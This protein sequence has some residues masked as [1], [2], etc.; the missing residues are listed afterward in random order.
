MTAY[1][2]V[3]RDLSKVTPQ[4]RNA[5]SGRTRFDNLEDFIKEHE[6]LLESFEAVTEIAKQNMNLVQLLL[7]QKDGTKPHIED[8]FAA[9][10]R[11]QANTIQ[12]TNQF[13]PGS[14]EKKMREYRG[15]LRG[16]LD[17]FGLAVMIDWTER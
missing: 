11:F 5:T 14:W 7:G 3:K 4:A 13:T 1:E 6:Q 9:F 16:E 12:M 10:Q 17:R 2:R 15:Q 8:V